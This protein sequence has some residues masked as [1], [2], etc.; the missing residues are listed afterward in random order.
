MNRFKW[1]KSNIVIV[2]INLLCLI[3]YALFTILF[4]YR[5][6]KLSGNQLA[7]SWQGSSEI[8]YHEISVF[9]DPEEQIKLDQISGIRSGIQSSLSD[10]S[11]TGESVTGR[12]WIDCY[13]AKRQ[14]V[15]S[16]LNDI[17]RTETQEVRIVGAGGDFFYFHEPRMISGCTFKDKDSSQDK[18]LID[19]QTAWSLFGGY[20]IAGQSVQVDGKN[21]IVSGVYEPKESK[22]ETVAKGE[23]CYLYMDYDAYHQA[24]DT[25]GI[26]CYEALIPNPVKDFAL[27]TVK[28][29]FGLSNEA[30]YEDS[31]TLSNQIYEFVDQ[32]SRFASFAVLKKIKNMPYLFMHGSNIAYPYWENAIR[33]AEL[34]L[35]LD[36]IFRVLCILPVILTIVIW[37]MKNRRKCKETAKLLLKAGIAKCIQMLK[38]RIKVKKNISED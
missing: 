18:V 25:D 30:L 17:G 23:E 24:Y 2:A 32:T 38:N 1:K 8:P 19:K 33:A 26:L 37:F 11:Y 16:R 28:Q 3:L 29:A 13:F 27:F 36:M 6:E 22:Y 21:Y 10:A 35:M 20:D 12:L 9:I 7:K 31:L 14:G 15:V 34:K 4:S 5:A